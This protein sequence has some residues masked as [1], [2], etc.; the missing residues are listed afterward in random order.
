MSRKNKMPYELHASVLRYVVC[1]ISN[2]ILGVNVIEKTMSDK[3]PH[4]MEV[5]GWVKQELEW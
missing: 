5:I 2:V 1:A 4:Q 3:S